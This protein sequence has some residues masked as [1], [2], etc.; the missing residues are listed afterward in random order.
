[1]TAELPTGNGSFLLGFETEYASKSAV[2]AHPDNAA[3]FLVS[4]PSI[5][6]R[7]SALF[8]EW[9]PSLGHWRFVLGTRVDHHDA[10]AGAAATGPDVPT[11]PGVLA[12]SFNKED[13]QWKESSVD[14]VARSWISSGN[15]TWRFSLARRHRAPSDIERFAWLPTPASGGLADGN[16]YVGDR[17]LRVETATTLDFGVDLNGTKWRL[18]P[19][20]FYSRIDDYIQ[21]TPYDT[22]PGITDS[23]VERVSAMNGDLTPLKFTNVD[24]RLYGLEI[25]GIYRLSPTLDIGLRYTQARGERTDVDDN[26]YRIAPPRLALHLDYTRDEWHLRLESVSH[27][28]QKRVATINGEPR[29]SGHTRFNLHTRWQP[30]PRLSVGVGVENV[31]DKRYQDHMAGF[32]RVA[33]SDVALGERLYGYGRNIYLRLQ[34]RR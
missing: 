7:D 31:T 29:T 13:R 26:L 17:A 8:A 25:E 28:A 30:D 16:T 22:T 9:S 5:R 32:N 3:F 21:G 11:M 14:V 6:L 15:A 34:I 4:L 2:I 24:A 27:D 12:T 20:V 1:M 33:E 18:R 10:R 19:T 23:V